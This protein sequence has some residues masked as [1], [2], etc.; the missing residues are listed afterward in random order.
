MNNVSRADG[1]TRLPNLAHVFEPT[2]KI[3][4]GDHHSPYAAK[5]DIADAPNTR[6]RKTVEAWLC[7]QEVSKLL[8]QLDKWKKPTVMKHRES[9][10]AR[11]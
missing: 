3:C 9:L 4:G 6:R 11:L 10:C 7:D 8:A 5:H 2:P 1:V